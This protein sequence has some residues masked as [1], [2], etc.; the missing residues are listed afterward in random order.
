MG[1]DRLFRQVVI[2]RRRDSQEFACAREVGLAR[3]SGEQAVVANA[4]EPAWQKVE[5]EAA[6][7]LVSAD[8]HDTL[9]VCAVAAIIL[10]A[11]GDAGR[12]EGKQPPVRDGDAVS[13]AREIGKHGFGAGE[14]RLG[15]D[16]PA[17][18]VDRREVTQERPPVS[19]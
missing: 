16:H 3:R 15:V 19:E 1:I 2:E 11:E 8:R 18:T 10:V 7:E 4:V 5:Q 6:D 17:L 12:V 9:A 14:G 13:V